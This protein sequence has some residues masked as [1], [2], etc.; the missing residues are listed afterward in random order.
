MPWLVLM[1]ALANVCFW[2]AS[3]LDGWSAGRSWCQPRDWRVDS[4]QWVGAVLC[5]AAAGV[6]AATHA[7]EMRAKGWRFDPL[8][9][10]W[11]AGLTLAAM[12]VWAAGLLIGM[13]LWDMAQQRWWDGK[14]DYD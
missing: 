8:A 10:A 11:V 5:L 6:A 2:T 13:R 14:R 7:A 1:L 4:L 3:W 12:A 9:F